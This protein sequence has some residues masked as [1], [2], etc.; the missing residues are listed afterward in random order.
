MKNCDIFLIFAQNIDRGYTFLNEAVLTSTH[1][2][3]FGQKYENSKKKIR[4]KIV[5]FTA[6]KYCSILHGHVFIMTGVNYS[7]THMSFRPNT[8]VLQLLS[9]RHPLETAFL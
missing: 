2:I 5:I 7:N 4:L 8:H 1:N 6:V 3:C 9:L